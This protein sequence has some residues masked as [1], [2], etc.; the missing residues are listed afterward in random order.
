MVS[1]LTTSP[2]SGVGG[3]LAEQLTSLRTMTAAELREAWRRLYRVQPPPRLR[4]DL[5]MLAVGWKLQEQALGGLS[6][7]TRRRLAAIASSPGDKGGATNAAER[8]LKPGAR[9]LREWHGKVHS[10]TV[11][12]EGYEWNGKSWPSLSAIAREITGARWSGPRFFGLTAS[13]ISRRV[14]EA[15][16]A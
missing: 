4:R 6:T 8:R 10:I 3:Q 7:A 9:L 16:D 12:D 5:L 13:S 11:L 1:N 2:S 15:D 14:S